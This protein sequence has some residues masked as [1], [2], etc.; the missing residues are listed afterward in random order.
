MRA[1]GGLDYVDWLTSLLLASTDTIRAGTAHAFDILW[2][3]RWA[4][5][6]DGSRHSAV[7][8][9]QPAG[10]TL[11]TVRHLL[12]TLRKKIEGDGILD[13]LSMDMAPLPL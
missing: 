11:P 2:V 7:L 9:S 10:A 6:R 1:R 13:N 3:E 4:A 5:P 8:Y 12:T